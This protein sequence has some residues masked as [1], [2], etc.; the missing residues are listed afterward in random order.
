[1]QLLKQIMQG[2][3]TESMQL[4]MGRGKRHQM[5]WVIGGKY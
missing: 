2:K 3:K 4:H 1:M 5:A